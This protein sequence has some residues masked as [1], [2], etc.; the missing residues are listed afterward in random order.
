MILKPFAA[1]IALAQAVATAPDF[2]TARI[3][4]GFWTYQATA[5]GSAARFIDSTGTARLVLEC[6]KASRRVSVSRTSATPAPSIFLW[7]S[8]AARSLPVRFEANAMR[9]TVELPAFDNLLDGIAFSRGRI[10]TVM[11]GAGPGAGTG[12]EVLVV[13]AWPEAARTIE[14][15]RI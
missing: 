13:P 5:A 12:A 15:C 4:P 14:D 10:A 3:A 7:T 8:S 1:L 11:A 6:T 2:S 9:V